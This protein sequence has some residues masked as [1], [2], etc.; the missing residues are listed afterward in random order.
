MKLDDLELKQFNLSDDERDRLSLPS[1]NLCSNCSGLMS[2]GEDEAMGICSQ[3]Y[4]EA[5]K[6]NE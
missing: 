3:C 5:N 6:E 4:Y 2:V 1:D